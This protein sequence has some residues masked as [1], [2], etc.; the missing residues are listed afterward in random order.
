[1]FGLLLN[2]DARL[3]PWA[4]EKI[5]GPYA[6]DAMAVGWGDSESVRAVLV[7]DCW[8]PEQCHV[9]IT[10]DGSGRFITRKFLAA[11]FYFPFVVHGRHRITG[12]IPR[13]NVPSLRFARH[14]GMKHE[15]TM[16]EAA[17]GR[18]DMIVLGMLRSECRFLPKDLRGE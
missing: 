2:D 16:R 11:G 14:L 10:S 6:A 4:E 18:S 9:H 13:S 7:Y 3:I 1:M 17:T 8:S 12:L 15:G 5:G